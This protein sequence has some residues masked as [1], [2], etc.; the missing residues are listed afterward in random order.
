VI[1]HRI[2]NVRRERKR[3]KGRKE[4]S[5]TGQL[6]SHPSSGARLSWPS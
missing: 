3:E 1:E 5:E 4:G 2:E 6:N